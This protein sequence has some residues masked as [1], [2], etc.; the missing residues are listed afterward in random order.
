MKNLLKILK[1]TWGIAAIVVFVLLM[2]AGLAMGESFINTLQVS[3]VITIV[4]VL[5]L[6]VKETFLL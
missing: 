3:V 1:S 2:I 4:G 5:I 6:W